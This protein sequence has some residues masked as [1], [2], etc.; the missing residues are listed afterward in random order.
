M[1]SATIDNG[2]C[3]YGIP[4]KVSGCTDPNA[5]NYSIS[6]N[7]DNGTCTYSESILSTGY[8]IPGCTNPDL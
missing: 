6:A 2:T 3:L 1:T 8:T 5:S 7:L 4:G